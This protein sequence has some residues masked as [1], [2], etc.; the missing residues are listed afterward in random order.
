MYIWGAQ[1]E[2]G[3]YATSYIPT[4]AATVTRN[5]DLMQKTSITSLIGQTEGVLFIDFIFNRQ[6]D[7]G[8][9]VSLNDGTVG[10]RVFLG[11][12]ATNNLMGLVGSSSIT[13]AIMS[14]TI[15]LGN[16]YKCAI[17]YKAN[18]FVLYV[19][20]VQAASDTSGIVPASLTRLSNDAGTTSTTP[21]EYPLNQLLVFKTRLSNA[22][23]ATL[24]TL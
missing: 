13:Q 19:N 4:T 23:L 11:V 2:A 10:N 22:D 8:D 12:N 9:L 3:A 6:V 16:R 5:I 1:V 14:Y 21:F 7:T 20:G 18:D 15:S 24:T 17:A